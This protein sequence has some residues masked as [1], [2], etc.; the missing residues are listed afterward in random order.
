[1]SIG[2]LAALPASVAGQAL[3][4]THGSE[5]ERAA[6]ETGAQQLR[7]AGERR[8]EAAAGIG[9][10]D[11]E[12]DEAHERDADGRRLWEDRLDLSHR[13]RDETTEQNSQEEQTPS[14]AVPRP[15]RSTTGPTL[16]ITA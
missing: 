15:S 5:V 2:P 14:P 12:G 8:A 13:S 1:M 4:Q 7:V 3:A 10:T 11:S 6:Q 9:Q 16:D